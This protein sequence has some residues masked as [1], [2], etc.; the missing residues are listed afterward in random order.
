MAVTVNQRNSRPGARNI[1]IGSSGVGRTAMEDGT[2]L[3]VTTTSALI[4]QTL[5][6]EIVSL[7]RRPGESILEKEIGAQFGVSR[8]PVREAILRL[9]AEKLVEIFP[10]S[11]TFV[12]RIPIDELPEAIVIRKALEEVAMRAA[13]EHAS[14]AQVTSLRANL[15]LQREAIAAENYDSFRSIDDAFHADIAK[16]AGYPGIWPIVRSLKIQ[17]DRYCHLT[18][19]KPGRMARLLREH[20]AIYRAIRDHDA[21]LAA[22]EL[23]AHIDGIMTGV[24]APE[25]IAEMVMTR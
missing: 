6:N 25:N 1:R 24:A 14:R 4:Y 11:G 19:P 10:Q 17:V 12:A 5:R 13:A 23:R 20:S 9:A 3:R 22:A 7:R 18:L 8:T 21:D 16:I 2:A 15:D